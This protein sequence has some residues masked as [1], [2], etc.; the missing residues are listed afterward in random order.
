[1][2]RSPF[3]STPQVRPRRKLS[4][5][6]QPVDL[7]YFSPAFLL[8]RTPLSPR[9]SSLHSWNL[10][11]GNSWPTVTAFRRFS[12]QTEKLRMGVLFP[13]PRSASLFLR[14]YIR[15]FTLFGQCSFHFLRLREVPPNPPGCLFIFLASVF[16]FFF[17]GACTCREPYSRYTYRSPY[18][19]KHSGR[20]SS[21]F[22]V[23]VFPLL[24][25]IF[26]YRPA[27][28]L[29]TSFRPFLFFPSGCSRRAVPSLS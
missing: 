6:A 22:Y 14:N 18:G 29:D 13:S 9:T 20:P 23:K 12:L 11:L 17:L 28:P 27:Y 8:F 4:A 1:V 10:V 3:F 21:E 19:W 26:P 7:P 5:L 16:L 2:S 25:S 15:G 24:T